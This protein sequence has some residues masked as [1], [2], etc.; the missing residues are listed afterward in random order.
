MN[1]GPRLVPL[2]S[3]PDAALRLYCFPPGGH[4]PGFYAPWTRHL[5]GPDLRAVELPGRA[6]LAGQPSW[7]DPNR[8]TAAVAGLV[9]EQDDGRPYALF[10]H[11][12][13]ALL[14]WETARRLHRTGHRPPALVAVSALPAP[15]LGSYVG[16]FSRILLDA[17]HSVPHLLGLTGLPAAS[18]AGPP[19]QLARFLPP[20]L[21]DVL[22]IWHHRHRDEEP[23]PVPL[24][25]YGGD[26]DPLVP[27]DQLPEWNDLV[28]TPATPVLFPGRHMYPVEQ[29]QSLTARLAL[30]LS[31]ALPPR[32]NNSS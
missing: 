22:L 8:V 21:A 25:L 2:A 18:V 11:S 10:G 27:S 23:L 5:P 4:G 24:A 29:A 16:T 9:A 32:R 12:I 26:A 7:T 20:L 17:R 19:D 15:H 3:R 1:S 30:D 6:T 14:A 13:G 28:V 31:A